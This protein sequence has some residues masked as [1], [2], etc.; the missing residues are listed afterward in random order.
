M[1][2]QLPPTHELPAS[3]S[4]GLSPLKPYLY[5]GKIG[6]ALWNF[7]SLI[8]LGANLFLLV[9]LLLVGRELFSLKKV[10]SDQLIEGLYTN[11]VKMDG[12]HIVTTILVSDTIQVSDTIPVV[13]DLPLAQKTEVKLTQDTPVN[14]ATI[15][16]NGRAVPLD[17]VLRKGT[18]LKIGLDLTVPVSQTIPVV[19]NVPVQMK[20]PVD[21][22]LDQTDLHRPFVGLQEVV[23]PYRE[24]LGG[25]P[26]S[27]RETP[28]CGGLTGWLCTWFFQL[29]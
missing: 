7:A 18:A 8:S 4:R 13:F 3:S 5:R 23:S 21:I 19:L 12:A 6:P 9:I 17:L 25:L 24:L 1:E 27:W 16:L 20:V 11:F 22:A 29:R 15:F 14:N 28:V 2:T 10:V 26:D